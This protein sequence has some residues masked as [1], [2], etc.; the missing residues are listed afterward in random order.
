MFYLN[1]PTLCI[2]KLQHFQITDFIYNIHHLLMS[3][4]SAYGSN[5]INKQLRDYT[6]ILNTHIYIHK[7]IV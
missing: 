3:L 2:Y 6:C 5:D 7:C 4:L 1:I